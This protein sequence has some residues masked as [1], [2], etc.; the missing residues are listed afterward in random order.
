M[1]N[2]LAHHG[3]KG[4]KWGVRRYQNYDG[5]LTSAGKQR[6]ITNGETTNHETSGSKS[7]SNAKKAALAAVLIGT[8]AAGAA[9]YG[10]NHEAINR[11]ITSAG[12]VT[13][14]SLKKGSAKAVERG[15][16]YVSAAAKQVVTGAKEGVKEGLREAPKKA[17][18]TVMAGATLNATKKIL[19]NTVGREESARIFQAANNKKVSSFWKV[20]QEDRDED[21]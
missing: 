4:M 11:V 21:D 20:Q 15:K 1:D 9:I 13:I 17:V 18:K 5:T 19:D 14:S 2:T 6:Y 8:V 10:R 16:K 3:V 7:G 12:K